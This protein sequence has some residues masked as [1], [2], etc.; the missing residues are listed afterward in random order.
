MINL[1]IKKIKKLIQEN[2]VVLESEKRGYTQGTHLGTV[3]LR[4]LGER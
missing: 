3:Q 4:L 2:R 1:K